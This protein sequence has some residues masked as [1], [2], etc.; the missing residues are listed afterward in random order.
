MLWIS[1]QF[2]ASIAQTCS[3]C[4]VR[5]SRN[6]A[7]HK[8]RAASL[9]TLRV[10]YRQTDNMSHSAFLKL[11]FD[12]DEGARRGPSSPQKRG[13]SDVSRRL[14]GALTRQIPRERTFFLKNP[15]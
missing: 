3:H 12:G 14:L 11:T 13:V 9:V 8:D 7:V 4:N 10:V 6:R 5:Y 2:V 15:G 1:V